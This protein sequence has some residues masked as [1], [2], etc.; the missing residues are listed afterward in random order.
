MNK[1]FPSA[2]EALKG[3]ALW[4]PE[5]AAT[6]AEGETFRHDWVGCDVFVGGQKVGEVLR[7]DPGPA[8]Y[9]MVILKDL[10]PGRVGQR[11]VLG[12]HALQSRLRADDVR[13][14]AHVRCAIPDRMPLEGPSSR[15]GHDR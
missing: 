15:L 6:L 10:R 1:I 12:H 8:G 13:R 5:S 4:M 14:H 3:W 9:D 7:L 2:A 11:D